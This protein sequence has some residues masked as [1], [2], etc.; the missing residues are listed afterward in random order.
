MAVAGGACTAYRLRLVDGAQSVK[1]TT[2]PRALC[3]EPRQA[4]AELE[5]GREVV[6][7]GS[8]VWAVREAMHNGNVL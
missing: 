1:Q 8:D 6:V 4:V 2:L 3:L 5:A 7:A